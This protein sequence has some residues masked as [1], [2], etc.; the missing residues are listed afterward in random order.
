MLGSGIFGRFSNRSIRVLLV[1]IV[2]FGLYTYLH[3]S[4]IRPGDTTATSLEELCTDDLCLP[5][6][7]STGLTSDETVQ[8]LGSVETNPDST[9]DAQQGETQF[10]LDKETND[11]LSSL[12]IH[13][14][15]VV[16][17]NEEDYG[18]I[19]K[20]LG[21]KRGT[22]PKTPS[23]Y[24]TSLSRTNRKWFKGSFK[25]QMEEMIR[26]FEKREMGLEGLE[27]KITSTDKDGVE[28]VP[29]G[30]EI[31][32]EVATRSDGWEVDVLDDQQ[33]EARI[34]DWASEQRI[35]GIWDKLDF[36]VLKTD[37]IRWVLPF[38]G[39]QSS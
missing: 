33:M 10:D 6:T 39:I 7:T 36:P 26:R 25:S 37:L 32:G 28:G 22:L 20:R 23:E 15:Q 21:M 34:R 29:S 14:Q 4:I 11:I 18:E 13:R 30:F 16:G 1:L 5:E 17:Y 31:W 9:E 8:D 27:R 38:L 12:E 2:I 24:Y 35:E 19:E 3:S